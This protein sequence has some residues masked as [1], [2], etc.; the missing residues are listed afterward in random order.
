MAATFLLFLLALTVNDGG[1][2]LRSGCS[3]D[4]TVLASLPAGASLKLRYAMSGESTPCYKVSAEMDGRSVDGYLPASS[5]D[6]LETFDKA[7]K[8]AAWAEVNTSAPA[9]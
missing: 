1:A 4:S 2:L 7:R 9:S 5:I 6:G 3:A 8:S